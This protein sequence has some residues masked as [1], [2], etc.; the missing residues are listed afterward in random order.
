MV[1]DDFFDEFEDG[2]ETFALNVQLI[3][4]VLLLLAGILTVLATS[5]T[6]QRN[7]TILLFLLIIVL[8]VAA[9][10]WFSEQSARDFFGGILSYLAFGASRVNFYISVIVG[11]G[12]GVFL[13][14]TALVILTPLAAVVTFA[15]LDQR[16]FA[17][18]F[19]VGLAPFVEEQFF[20]GLLVP[21]F[22]NLGRDN[23]VF[24][25]VLMSL[26]V[27]SLP[28]LF[29]EFL[30]AVLLGAATF[31]FLTFI[32]LSEGFV[33]DLAMIVIASIPFGL[34]HLYAYGGQL[35]NVLLAVG[36]GFAMAFGN[37]FFKTTGFGLGVH[38]ANN[39]VVHLRQFG[40]F[41]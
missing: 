25:R 32:P 20:R 29:G 12:L 9:I 23:E 26:V 18:L 39:A 19:N 7:A 21:T 17:L 3:L 33:R 30:I 34:F 2:E 11:L 36:F 6:A 5:E 14:G 4:L 13:S 16:F 8:I 10:E 38:W 35:N 41:L 1:L 15:N 40:S 28:V 37:Y 31:A 27:M 22:I 24:Q